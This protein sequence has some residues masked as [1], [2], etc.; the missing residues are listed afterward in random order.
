MLNEC[1]LLSDAIPLT[2]PARSTFYRLEPASIDTAER[3][4]LSSYFC[5]LADAHCLSPF[6]L[7]DIMGRP[8]KGQTNNRWSRAAWQ[9]PLFNGPGEDPRIWST[10]LEAMTSVK[11]L[12]RLTMLQLGDVVVLSGLMAKTKKWCPLCLGEASHKGMP[13]GKLIWE[14][15][16]VTACPAHGVKLADRCSCGPEQHHKRMQAK[17]LHHICKYCGADLSTCSAPV[18]TAEAGELITAK[19]ISQFLASDCFNYPIQRSGFREFLTTIIDQQFDGKAAWLA[20]AIGV[21]KANMH[22]W[23]NGVRAPSLVRLVKIAQVSQSPIEDILRGE[24]RN[25]SMSSPNAVSSSNSKGRRTNVDRLSILS[26]LRSYLMRNEPVSVAEIARHLGV[27]KRYIYLNF[28]AIA[29]ELASRRLKVLSERTKA[30]LRELEFRYRTTARSL[31]AQGIIPGWRQLR[32]ALGYYG[33]PF[34]PDLRNLWRRV[35]AEELERAELDP[36]G[37]T[38]LT[39][40]QR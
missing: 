3:E 33:N 28:N 31:L 19:L 17:Y 16:A 11:D 23:L 36:I 9:K 1:P 22:E 12:R 38:N 14:I 29:K 8:G 10:L 13:Y 15:G 7:T 30:E 4:S 6:Q 39:H 32:A 37:L 25:V 35:R 26:Q 5:R 34:A 20:G 24:T 2:M 40:R 18:Q 27:S 21:G